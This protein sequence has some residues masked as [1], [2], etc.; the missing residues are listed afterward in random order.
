MNAHMI[1]KTPCLM[2]CRVLARY[3]S[4]PCISP[5]DVRELLDGRHESGPANVLRGEQRPGL[6]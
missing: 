3:A 5:L 2:S 4:I 1:E 6:V